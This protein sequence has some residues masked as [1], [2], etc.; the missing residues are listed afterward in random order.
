MKNQK[1]GVDRRAK[2]GIRKVKLHYESRECVNKVFS[3]FS[4]IKYEAKYKLIHE[5]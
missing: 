3:D 5:K 1:E 2:N 4:S